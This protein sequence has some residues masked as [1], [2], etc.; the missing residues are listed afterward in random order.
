MLEKV[1]KIALDKDCC[2][3]TLEVF[4]G[5]LVAQKSYRKFGFSAYEL[6]PEMGQALFWEKAL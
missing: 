1:E 3:L 2:K 6:A 4:E 5:N